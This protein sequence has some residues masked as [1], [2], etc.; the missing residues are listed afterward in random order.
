MASENPEMDAQEN[1]ADTQVEV[2]VLAEN[3]GAEGQAD[4]VAEAVEE[5]AE[6]LEIDGP[7]AEAAAESSAESGEQEA[8]DEAE[9]NVLVVDA[10]PGDEEAQSETVAELAGELTSETPSDEE[11]HAEAEGSAT[12]SASEV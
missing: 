1:T 7:E 5:H 9:A 4:V 11:S 12:E 10:T 6:Q 2:A 3:T 8:P